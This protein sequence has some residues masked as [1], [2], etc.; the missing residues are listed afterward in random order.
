MSTVF[1]IGDGPLAGELG[2]AAKRA[3]HEVIALLDPTLL[4]VTS[5]DPTPF[6]EENRELWLRACHADLIIDA[7]VSNRLAKRRAVIEA[8]GWSPAPILTSTLTASA[9][10]VAF[11]LGEAGR[12][13]GWAALPPLAETRVVEVM[14]AMEA[15]SEAVEVAQ[16]FF[17][18]LDKEP[19]TVGDSVGGVLPR[20][21]ATLINEAAFA[22]MERVAGADD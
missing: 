8:S 1:L 2:V 19:V 21:V 13:V 6:E 7:V 20:V 3:G 18:S 12:V 22:L 11:W 4:G 16:D 14:P 9:T 5:D 15:S 17:R 10:E